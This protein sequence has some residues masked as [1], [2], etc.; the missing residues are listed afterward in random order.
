MLKTVEGTYQNGEVVLAEPP[1]AVQ[2]SRV[3]V[4]FLGAVEETP[5][6]AALDRDRARELRWRLRSVAEDWDRPEM[7]VYDQL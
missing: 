4:T 5:A 3:L 2:D 6:A 1:P 7:S